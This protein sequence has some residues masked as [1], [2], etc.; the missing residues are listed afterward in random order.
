MC[1]HGNSASYYSAM[2]YDTDN[3]RCVTVLK[4]SRAV[5]TYLYVDSNKG[6]EAIPRALLERF[7]EPREVLSLCLTP[8]RRLANADAAAVLRALSEKGYYL[9]LPPGR[10][11]WAA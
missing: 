4:G 6:T 1:W 8:E 3:A 5:D 9:Q 7:G 10:K 11:E 2:R